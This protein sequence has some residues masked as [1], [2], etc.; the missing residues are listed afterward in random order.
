MLY[1]PLFW[2][3][4]VIACVHYCWRHNDVSLKLIYSARLSFRSVFLPVYTLCLFSKTLTGISSHL[5]QRGL[6]LMAPST[7]GRWKFSYLG[8]ATEGKG[9]T[10][11]DLL[12]FTPTWHCYSVICSI[13]S[14]WQSIDVKTHVVICWFAVSSSEYLWPRERCFDEWKVL[15]VEMFPHYTQTP[16]LLVLLVDFLQTLM[17]IGKTTGN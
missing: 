12:V 2:F 13:L 5:Q 7:F 11:F 3:T 6:W 16:L 9:D 14:K 17:W 15:A 4:P 10:V 1:F 8:T